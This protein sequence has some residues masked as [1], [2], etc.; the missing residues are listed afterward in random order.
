MQ[1]FIDFLGW[2][3]SLR[4]PGGWAEW[5][6]GAAWLQAAGCAAWGRPGCG[7]EAGVQGAGRGQPLT[8]HLQDLVAEVGLEVEGAVGREHEP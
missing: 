7:A 2:C 3:P 8:L 1:I 6:G 5:A 4:V